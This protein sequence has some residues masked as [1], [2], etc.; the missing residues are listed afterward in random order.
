MFVNYAVNGSSS[1]S[2]K[3]KDI[4][5]EYENEDSGN[6]GGL[7]GNTNSE[8]KRIELTP[9]AAIKDIYS[10][11]LSIKSDDKIP[12]DFEVNDIALT[13]REKSAK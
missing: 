11:S 5:N 2:G 4:T 13:Y 1:Y 9:T 6:H 3:F 10:I 12:Q 8:W 7:Q